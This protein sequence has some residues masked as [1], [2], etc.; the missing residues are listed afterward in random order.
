MI[1]RAASKL[2]IAS[3]RWSAVRIGH[4]VVIFV[5]STSAK[6]PID[7]FIDPEGYRVFLDAAE[8]ELREGRVH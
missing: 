8:A 5:A 3:G 6:N 7:P 1:V 4:Q 2:E